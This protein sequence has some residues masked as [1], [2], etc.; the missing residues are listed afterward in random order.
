MWES[1]VYEVVREVEAELESE[2]MAVKGPRYPWIRGGGQTTPQNRNRL[3][4]VGATGKPTAGQRAKQ[5]QAALAAVTAAV[6]SGSDEERKEMG[7]RFCSAYR[8]FSAEYP[9]LK[10]AFGPRH[11]AICVEK[12]HLLK[13]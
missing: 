10:T 5:L 7:I 2:A 11:Q 13:R 8:Q 4:S 6:A 1:E 3:R 12:R 9:G